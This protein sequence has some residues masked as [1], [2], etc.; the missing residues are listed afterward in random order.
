MFLVD[1]KSVKYVLFVY[2]N[3]FSIT[4]TPKVRK[5]KLKIYYLC[6]KKVNRFFFCEILYLCTELIIVAPQMWRG[7]VMRQHHLRRPSALFL[8]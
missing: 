6:A 5:Q 7:F 4:K 1:V 2:S 3:Q 8:S